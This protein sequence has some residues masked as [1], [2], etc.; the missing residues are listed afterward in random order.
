M[1]PC[2][3]LCF[4]LRDT[5]DFHDLLHSLVLLEDQHPDFR[6]IQLLLAPERKREIK[7]SGRQYRKISLDDFE[8]LE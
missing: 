4:A 3:S 6:A 5:P 1:S 8:L 2:L 7:C